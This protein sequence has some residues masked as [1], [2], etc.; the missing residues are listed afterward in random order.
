MDTDKNYRSITEDG[1]FDDRPEILPPTAE[2]ARQYDDILKLSNVRASQIANKTIHGGTEDCIDIVRGHDLR[3]EN[4]RLLPVKNGITIKGAADF[5]DFIGLEFLL[6]GKDQEIE[7]G[8]FDNYWY[9]GRETPWWCTFRGRGRT[10]GKP[11]RIKVWDF[12]LDEADVDF[13]TGVEII[14]VP[15]WIWFPYFLFQY[16]RIRVTNVIRR[17]RKQ[18]L[19]ATK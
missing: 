11:V 17:I 15:K 16:V 4:V 8:Q 7:L 9:P 18:P 6:P 12:E 10:D 1:T 2:E 13:E 5:V 19:I 14:R 3:F